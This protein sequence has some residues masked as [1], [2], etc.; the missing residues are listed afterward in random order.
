MSIALGPLFVPLVNTTPEPLDP[1]ATVAEMRDVLIAHGVDPDV[2]ATIAREWVAA[3]AVDRV[4]LAAPG[5]R[6]GGG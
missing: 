6:A 2:A 4:A 3:H 1:P 5:G